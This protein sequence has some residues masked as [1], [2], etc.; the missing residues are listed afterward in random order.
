LLQ[1]QREVLA[2]LAGVMFLNVFQQL[3]Q[4]ARIVLDVEIDRIVE[5]DAVDVEVVDPVA[6]G[7]VNEFLGAAIV[8]IEIEQAGEASPKG[9]T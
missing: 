5:A 8:I 4:A 9:A 7:I 6:A 2:A 3:R 1:R